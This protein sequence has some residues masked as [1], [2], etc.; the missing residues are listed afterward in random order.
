MNDINCPELR[1]KIENDEVFLLDVREAYE[2]TAENIG[3]LNIPMSELPNRVPEI[4]KDKTVVIYCR[5][6]ARSQSVIMFLQDNFGYT[7]LV[8]LDGGILTCS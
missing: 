4:P 2:Y 8:N 1:K 7:N 6:G 5:S 3:G